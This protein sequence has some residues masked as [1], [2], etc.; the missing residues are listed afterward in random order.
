MLLTGR[1]G[2]VALIDAMTLELKRE[3]H[4]THAGMNSIR[5]S[6]FLHNATMFALAEK[7]A[8]YIYDDQGAE[9]HHMQD[10]IDPL[11]ID[12]LPYHWLLCSIGRSG[13]LKYTDTSCGDKVAEFR[14]KLGSCGVMRQNP[15]N[16]VMHLGHGNGCVTMYSPAMSTPL[17]KML[18]HRGPV[19]ALANDLGGNYMVTAGADMLVKVWDL[20]TFKE[21]HSYFSRNEVTSLDISQ[22][23]ILAVGAGTAV[24]LWKDAMKEKQK[25]PYMSHRI[26]G[27]GVRCNIARFRPFEDVVGIGHEKGFSSIVVPGAGD[28]NYDSFENNMFQDRKQ[29]QE[30]EVKSL[31]DKLSPDMIQLDPEQVGTV[32]RDRKAIIT[33]QREKASKAD[34]RAKKEKKR[35]R[36]RNKISKKIARKHKNI[37]DESKLKLI[38]KRKEEMQNKGE[39]TDGFLSAQEKRRIKGV[40]EGGALSRFY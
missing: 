4:L 33:A 3:F 39:N 38:Q 12:Y 36:G 17:V 11:A 34:T 16:A 19:T 13:W 28:A 10:H 21:V 2:H 27:G 32:E 23:G 31:L 30:Q 9:I 37:M 25:S 8:V 22:T 18:C 40:E 14:T 20:R 7:K 24:T 6:T 35:A 1:T 29:R 26:L 15:H 5:S